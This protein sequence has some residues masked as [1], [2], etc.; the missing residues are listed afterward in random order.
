MSEVVSMNVP[1]EVIQKIV[2]SEVSAR[3]IA[4]LVNHESLISNL[5]ER[6]LHHKVDYQGRESSSSYDSKTYITW[7][8]EKLIKDSL[9]TSVKDYVATCKD[10]IQAEIEKQ[11]KKNTE[12]FVQ[13]FMG[14]IL[15][16]AKSNYLLKVEV[17]A[18]K[19]KE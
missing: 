1:N 9:E 10:K 8:C 17:K 13:A 18:E 7:V 12:P 19:A 2:Q 4:A 14:A 16:S 15:N 3:V 5:I 6:T 11:L